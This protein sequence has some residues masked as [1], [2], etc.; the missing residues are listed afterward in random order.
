VGVVAEVEAE[1]AAAVL[2]AE[3]A[4]AAEAVVAAEEVRR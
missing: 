4:V 3:V 1:E 2:P